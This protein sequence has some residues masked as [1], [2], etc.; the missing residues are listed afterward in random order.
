MLQQLTAQA[1]ALGADVMFCHYRD[2]DQVEVD[3]VLTS[4][5]KVWGVEVKAGSTM[6]GA[7]GAGLRRLGDATGHNFQR[8]IVLY[9]G[10]STLPTGDPRILAVPLSEL[11]TW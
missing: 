4:G 6:A 10:T 11:W 9:G 2:K 7:D 8:G 1:A 3:V 5:R